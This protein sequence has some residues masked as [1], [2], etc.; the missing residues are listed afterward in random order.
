MLYF[1]LRISGRSKVLSPFVGHPKLPPSY[2]MSVVV[3]EVN[4]DH[5]NCGHNSFL[6]RY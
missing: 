1:V 6:S 2:T 4:S 3:E 5:L